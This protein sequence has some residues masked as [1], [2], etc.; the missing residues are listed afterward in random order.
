MLPTQM[1][2]R[3]LA[4][5]RDWNG[6]FFFGVRT[7]GVFCLPSCA[8][9]KPRPENVLFFPTCEAARAA[10]FRACRKCHPDDFARGAD[11]VLEAIEALVAEVRDR[12]GDFADTRGLVRRSGFGPTRLAELLR[13]HY[14]ATPADLLRQ[15]RLVHARGRLQAGDA[16]L[17]DVAGEAGFA[18]LSVFH[19]QFRSHH[20]LA[21]AAYRALRSQDTFTLELPTGYPLAHLR[22]ALGRD[23][24]SV[25]ERLDGDS[26]TAGVRLDGEPARLRLQLGAKRVKVTTSTG[27]AFAAHAVA[28]GWLGL[29]QDA[30]GCARLARGLGLGRLVAGRPG[31]R[32]VQTPTVFDGLTWAVLGQQITLGFAFVI[33]RRLV[34]LAGTPVGEGLFAPPDPAEIAALEPAQLR[35]LQCSENKAKVLIGLARRIVSGEFPAAGLQRLSATRAERV[36][37]AQP[38]LGP[39]SVNYVMMRA[40][41]FADCVPYGDTGLTSGLQILLR[42]E[43]RP[44]LDATRRLMAIFSPHRSLATA[45]LW[46]LKAAG[47]KLPGN[48]PVTRTRS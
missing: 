43:E 11:P 40:L 29:D 3:V 9:R 41:G 7:T 37:L 4:G 22:R 48:S 13:Q 12:P 39:W 42:L 18:S 8:A 2:D 31:L 45:H 46:Q 6:R 10:G 28:S 47:K 26:F 23:P 38:G 36:L 17:T 24:Q 32:L 16:A 44:D 19:E 30:A 27:S 14:H 15:A 21:P 1:H 25:S 33:R 35:A 20:G 5:D 34:E